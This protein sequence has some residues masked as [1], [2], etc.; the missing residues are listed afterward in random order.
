MLLDKNKEICLNIEI[1]KAHKEFRIYPTQNLS[2][3]VVKCYQ[4]FKNRFVEIKICRD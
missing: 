1:I 4:A 2:Y 3:N